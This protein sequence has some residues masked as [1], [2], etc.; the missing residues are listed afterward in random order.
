MRRWRS[1]R[2]G[3]RRL[4]AYR[5][6]LDVRSLLLVTG[7]CGRIAEF[8]ISVSAWRRPVRFFMETGSQ[9]TGAPKRNWHCQNPS[10]GA[11]SAS[12]IPW[13]RLCIVSSS[14]AT[15]PGCNHGIRNKLDVPS[16]TSPATHKPLYDGTATAAACFD[17]SQLFAE[18]IGASPSN[19]QTKD[20]TPRGRSCRV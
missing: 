3:S 9:C 11:I 12:V 5:V 7:T 4:L 18:P 2:G 13:I 14:P 19:R 20:V 1:S 8:P 16:G 6:G 17:R 10:K 15:A